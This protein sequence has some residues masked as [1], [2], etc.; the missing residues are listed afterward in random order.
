MSAPVGV[1]SWSGRVWTGLQWWPP[2]VISKGMGVPVLWGPMSG[3][4]ELVPGHAGS[5]QWDPMHHGQWSHGTPVNRQTDTTESI[6]FPQVRWRAVKILDIDEGN[7]SGFAGVS[8]WGAA[9]EKGHIVKVPRRIFNMLPVL[10]F[11]RMSFN[12]FHMTRCLGWRGL[13]MWCQA[14]FSQENTL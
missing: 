2:D 10:T 7:N 6:T 13:G 9:E 4:G 12:G 14:Y 5:V 1:G 3:G 8:Q 11:Y